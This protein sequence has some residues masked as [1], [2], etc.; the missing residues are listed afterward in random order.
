VN[1]EAGRTVTVAHQVTL[2]PK[3]QLAAI[4]HSSGVLPSESAP[5]ITANSSHHQ[6]ADVPG[7]GLRLVARCPVDQVK[8]A[9]EGTD[10]DHFVLALQWHPERTYYSDPASRAMFQA[11]VRA[12]A[13]W[14]KTERAQL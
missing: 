2:D 12:A 5:V 7:D 1:H 13:K 6:A 3:S 10:D 4:L 14:H 11:F 8:E 9:V